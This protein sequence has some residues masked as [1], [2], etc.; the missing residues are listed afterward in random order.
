MAVRVRSDS[1]DAP[2]ARVNSIQMDIPANA[3]QQECIA[4]VDVYLVFKHACLQEVDIWID[5]PGPFTANPSAA[6]YEL[7]VGAPETSAC[8]LQYGVSVNRLNAVCAQSRTQT[9]CISS[10]EAQALAQPIAMSHVSSSS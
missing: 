6:S 4:D 2:Q 8:S 9:A 1:R 5:G 7:G 10:W 3:E